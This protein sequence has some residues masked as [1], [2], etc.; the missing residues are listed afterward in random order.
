LKILKHQ[1]E[2][3]KKLIAGLFGHS[4]LPHKA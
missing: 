2:W 1:H 4:V 3:L